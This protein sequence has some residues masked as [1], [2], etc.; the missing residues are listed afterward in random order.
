MTSS[1]FSSNHRNILNFYILSNAFLENRQEDLFLEIP[2]WV[3]INAFPEKL[4]QDKKVIA[5]PSSSMIS[6]GQ[7][8][9]EGRQ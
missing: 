2:G 1:I 4:L 5:S 6:T 3:Q 7:T 9:T 8:T